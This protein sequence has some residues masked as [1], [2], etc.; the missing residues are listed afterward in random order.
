M[1][2]L[3]VTNPTATTLQTRIIIINPVCLKK[4]PTGFLRFKLSSSSYWLNFFRA[5]NT[6]RLGIKIKVNFSPLT[7]LLT[8]LIHLIGGLWF[9]IWK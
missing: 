9:E 2:K 1:I 8:L 5:K 3:A 6:K 4:D 7:L